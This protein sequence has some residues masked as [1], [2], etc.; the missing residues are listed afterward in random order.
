MARFRTS[1]G[2]R[3]AT[4]FALHGIA[5][6]GRFLLPAET[7]T[8]CFRTGRGP[9][10]CAADGGHAMGIST[11]FSPEATTK[12]DPMWEASSRYGLSTSAVVCSRKLPPLLTR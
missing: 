1:H 12:R 9:R 11:Y 3:T 10:D 6:S 2:V 8:P 4:A 7:F 5:C